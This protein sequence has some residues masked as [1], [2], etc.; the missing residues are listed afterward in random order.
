MCERDY[1]QTSE[2]LFIWLSQQRENIMQISGL[3]LQENAI[4]FCRKMKDDNFS[5]YVVLVIRVGASPDQLGLS[6]LDCN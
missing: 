3:M 4:Y 5:Y 2:A 1:K 6:G